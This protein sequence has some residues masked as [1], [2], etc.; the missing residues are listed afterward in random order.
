MKKSIDLFPT[1]SVTWRSVCVMLKGPLNCNGAP[2]CRHSWLRSVIWGI[3]GAFWLD[4]EYPGSW[5]RSRRFILQCLCLQ[6]ACWLGPNLGYPL[7]LD[8]L[9]WEVWCFTLSVVFSCPPGFRAIARIWVCTF[10]CFLFSFLEAWLLKTMKA[11]STSYELWCEHP[12]SP[13]E[14]LEFPPNIWST[15]N[16]EGH[17]AD[18]GVLG[19]VGI[20]VS[21]LIVTLAN[22][23]QEFWWI[24]LSSLSSEHLNFMEILLFKYSLP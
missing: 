5:L 22:L 18:L 12:I 1:A 7:K 19:S 14:H 13:L 11:I 9:G 23:H 10:I 8:H 21:A 16:Y 20:W 15:L 6:Q 4:L 24:F 3:C 17:A 2:R